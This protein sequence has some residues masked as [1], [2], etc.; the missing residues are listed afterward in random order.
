M[1]RVMQANFHFED[2]DISRRELNRA[3]HNADVV[4]GFF[5]SRETFFF[6]SSFRFDRE[7]LKMHKE[8]K[9]TVNVLE[10]IDFFAVLARGRRGE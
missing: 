4:R 2:W 3:A 9:K 8:I 6:F 1:C 5:S 7:K 10:L